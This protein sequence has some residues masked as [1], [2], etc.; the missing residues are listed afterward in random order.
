M[1]S[2]HEQQA[3]GSA[4]ESP[5]H[6]P[7]PLAED[8]QDDVPRSLR[9]TLILAA[10][11]LGVIYGDIGTSTLY[12]LNGLFPATGPVPSDEDVVG[13]VSCII[14]TILLVPVVKYCLIALEFG[15]KDGE[16][17]PFAIYTSLFPPRES[18]R[19]GFS[20]LTTYT[21][22][23]SPP[24]SRTATR[25]L[26][27]PTFKF[28]LF[29]LVLLAVS[30]TI[31]D[32]MLTPAVSVVS[33]V[34][35]IAV[36]VP[37]VSSSIVGISCAILVVLFLVQALGTRR[38]AFLFSPVIAL[39]LVLNGVGGAINIAKHPA[40]FRA[41]D[42]SRAVML[43]VRTGNF[44]LLNGVILAITG[45]EALFANLAHFSKSS[46]RLAFMWFATPMLIL[47]YLG[48]GARLIDNGTDILPNV[49]FRSIPGGVN[50]PFWWVTWAVA[51]LSAVIASQAMITATFSLVQQLTK[52]HVLPPLR[53]VYTDDASQGRIYVPMVNFL[54][55]IGTIGLTVGFGTDA[56]LT[57]AYGFAVSGVL[58]ITT[59]MVALAM[60]QLKHLPVFIAVVYFI[61]SAFI[62]GLF[63]GATSLKVPHGAWFPLGLACV[64]LTLLLLWSWAKSLEDEFDHLH[65]YRLSEIM[66]PV[67]PDEG[68]EDE[69]V[70]VNEEK[71]RRC[72]TEE[73]IG[74]VEDAAARVPRLRRRPKLLEYEM[75]G[76]G[77]ELAR[78]PVFAMF[79]NHSSSSG[80]G[81]PH[82][83]TAFLRSY[84]AL[85]QV[86]IFL[87]V[88]PVGVPHVSPSDRYLLTRL[89]RFEGVYTATLSFGYRD[90][91]DLA[92]VAGPLRTRIVALETRAA[93]G[94][95]ELAE[96]VGKVERAVKGA[97]THILPHFRVSADQSPHRPKLLR[98]IRTFLLEEVFRRVAVNFDATDQFKF[99]SEEDVLR[100]GVTAV[101]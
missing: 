17:G 79:H 52:L 53:I 47:Q 76:G 68:E 70:P 49:F 35:G 34:G 43:F 71:E 85:P 98:L 51:I 15:T 59:T 20:A 82:S 80:E 61:L 5:G 87:T 50:K 99:G 74:P 21:E 86:I 64:L 31:A 66:R 2:Q 7:S 73:E 63:F 55:L 4:F 58:L 81:A 24:S 16:G 42:P 57:A 33:A 37:G 23:T 45:V 25:F 88:R 29:T 14:W 97:V 19:D 69:P 67:D 83:F 1:E 72:G 32:G 94:V 84:P 3:R 22:A 39:W 26:H 8:R 6:T 27:K 11:S 30:L 9:Q 13:G 60:V 44:G 36:A 40:I 77:A 93:R 78:P 28:A 92:D 18:K 12:C 54:L 89:A 90:E 65:R 41:F 91:V 100:M 38:I 46:I 56:G 62:D 95:E 101:L 75:Q 10:L 48:Q 96:R